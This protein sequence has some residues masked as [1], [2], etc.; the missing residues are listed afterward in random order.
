M[1]GRREVGIISH[2][3]VTSRDLKQERLF[4]RWNVSTFLQVVIGSSFG[5]IPFCFIV[6]G[7]HGSWL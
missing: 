2:R 6:K 5:A 7:G 4:F 1:G 3:L